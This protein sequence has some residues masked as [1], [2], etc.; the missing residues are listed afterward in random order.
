[1]R[2]LCAGFVVFGLF[3]AAAELADVTADSLRSEIS[4]LADDARQGRKTPSPELNASADYLAA[5]FQEAGLAPGGGDD[6]WF[7]V[8]LDT[9]SAKAAANPPRNVAGILRGSDPAVRGQFVIVSAHYDH[10]GAKRGRVYP[11]AND[12][13]SGTASLIEI[14]KQMRELHPRR[15]VMFLALFGEEEGLLGSQYYVAHPL[16]P[17]ARTVADI[18]LEQLGRTDTAD[19]RKIARFAFTGPSFS[20]LVKI[21]TPAVMSR[22]VTVFKKGD[23]DD[24]FTRS[25]NFEFA[26]AG[27]VAH[28]L[29]VAF[30]FRDYH[31]QGDTPEK[32]DYQNLAKLDEAIAAGVAAV[33]DADQPPK[34]ANI[35]ETKQYRKSF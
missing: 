11:G 18:N 10:L 23:A 28:T 3:G 14:A 27:V 7:Q 26:K 31:A 15:S 16:I 35:P 2:R 34:W 13:A 19:G 20:D 25:D 33:A 17:L 21:M 30:E 1:M 4:W 22:G 9:D 8:A 5:K 12:D 32:I 6:G 24:Y 29:V